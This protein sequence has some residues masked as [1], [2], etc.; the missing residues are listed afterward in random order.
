MIKNKKAI[1]DFDLNTFIDIK[2]TYDYNIMTTFCD[3]YNTNTCRSCSLID[4]DYQNQIKIKENLLKH[5]LDSL[6]IDSAVLLKTQIGQIQHFRNKAKLSVTGTTANPILGLLGDE[7]LDDGREILNCPLHRRNINE[8]LPVIKKFITH[9]NLTPYNIKNKN[10]ELKGIILFESQTTQEIYL[11][12]ILR[13]KESL[14]RIK[15]HLVKITQINPK[16][17]CISVNIQP[18]AHAI[19]EGEE[20]IILTSVDR[21]RHEA[22]GFKLKIGPQAFIQTNQEVAKKLYMAASEWVRDLNITNFSEVFCG[23]G[24]FSFHAQA[25]IKQGLGIEISDSAVK[26]ANQSA[27]ENNIHHLKFICADSK[28]AARDLRLFRPDLVLVNPPRRG[29]AESLN[30]LMTEKFNFI[31]YSSCSHETLIQDL[32][33]LKKIYEIKKVQIFD[34]FPHTKHFETLVLLTLKHT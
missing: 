16:V 32:E 27:L 8:L 25:F 11:R 14:D 1:I 3:Y 30:W 22:N 10:G 13:S 12:F 29:L 20:E 31:I 33:Q 5:K 26:K 15:K 21:V 17:V 9:A 23:Q 34:M 19:L 4:Q 2:L 28:D 24:L 7:S 6:G 18:I